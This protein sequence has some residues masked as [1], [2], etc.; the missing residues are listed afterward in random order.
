M[1]T[2]PRGQS[3]SFF[4]VS[5]REEGTGGQLREMSELKGQFML[6][7][8]TGGMASLL[9]HLQRIWGLFPKMACFK[10]SLTVGF[11]QRLALRQGLG[12]HHLPGRKCENNNNS[13]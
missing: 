11:P 13:R 7:A 12:P 3:L 5:H 6:L 8:T 10:P 2:Y 1:R 9:G 4:P